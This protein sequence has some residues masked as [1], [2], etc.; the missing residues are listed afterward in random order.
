MKRIKAIGALL[1]A[2]FA[3]GAVAAASASAGV[4]EFGTCVKVAGTGAY[5]N[6][7]CTAPS[8]GHTGAYEWQPQ[9]GTATF[10][11]TGL[12]K[13]V[14]EAQPPKPIKIECESSEATGKYTGPKTVEATWVLNG[15]RTGS[16]A[17]PCQSGLT[18]GKIETLPLTGELGFINKSVPTVG[19]DYKPTAGNNLLVAECGAGL[20]PEIATVSGS[21][22]GQVSK[23]DT[24][25]GYRKVRFLQ[26]EGVQRVEQLEGGVKDIPLLSYTA[27]EPLVE[28][29]SGLKAIFVVASSERTEVKAI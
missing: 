2:A 1:I 15:C 16:G 27:T 5:E 9:A 20:T 23:V 22:I 24:A 6:K 4:P 18:P 10:T 13:L 21:V 25:N 12:K 3:L 28:A 7:V 8:S 17:K 11:Y 14:L 26:S 29:P 19:L